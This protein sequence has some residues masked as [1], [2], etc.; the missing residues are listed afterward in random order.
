MNQ[1]H[2]CTPVCKALEEARWLADFARQGSPAGEVRLQTDPRTE[3]LADAVERLAKVLEAIVE[4]VAYSCLS[5]T[6]LRKHE[7]SVPV[8]DHLEDNQ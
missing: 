1:P 3:A 5:G 8:S 7:V 4:K 6:D 2:Y